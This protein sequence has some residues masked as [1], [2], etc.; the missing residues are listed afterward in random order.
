MVYDGRNTVNNIEN[1]IINQ[2]IHN[3]FKSVKTMNTQMNGK[4]CNT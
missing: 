3:V 4:Q 1:S 2:E